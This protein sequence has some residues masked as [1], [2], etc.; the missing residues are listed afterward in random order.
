M[1]TPASG[2][3]RFGLRRTSTC[4]SPLGRSRVAPISLA[5]LSAGTITGRSPT[6]ATS[7]PRPPRGW[8]TPGRR[9]SPTPWV[10]TDLDAEAELLGVGLPCLQL[11]DLGEGIVGDGRSRLGTEVLGDIDAHCRDHLGGDFTVN[12][13][14]RLPALPVGRQGQHHRQHRPT[15]QSLA[16]RASPPWTSTTWATMARPRP[17]SSTAWPRRR[18]AVEDPAPGPQEGGMPGPWLGDDEPDDAAP[19]MTRVTSAGVPTKSENLSALS[20]GCTPSAP[21]GRHRRPV[22]GSV[23][24]AI[25][26]PVRSRLWRAARATISSTERPRCRG[27][28]ALVGGQIDKLGDQLAQLLDFGHD[29]QQAVPLV[30]VDVGPP[31]ADDFGAGAQAG[32]RGAH[33]A[34]VLDELLLLAP[35]MQRAP[36]MVLNKRA[37]RPTSSSPCTGM[38]VVAGPGWPPPARRCQRTPAPGR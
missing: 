5:T 38:G 30:G 13:G 26:R 29:G 21:A 6:V 34:G 22:S 1:S 10:P 31:L 28:R 24:R 35:R 23:D 33:V 17:S 12:A 36:S 32:Q 8:R 19:T 18:E 9:G 15:P 20:G 14:L 25:S 7:R 37:K 11:Q 2:L 3:G 27:Q 4:W 16:A